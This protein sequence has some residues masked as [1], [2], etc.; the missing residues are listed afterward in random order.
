[1]SVKFLKRIRT[2]SNIEERHNIFEFKRKFK[3]KRK[4]QNWRKI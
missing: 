3:Q 4:G 1:M 2:S